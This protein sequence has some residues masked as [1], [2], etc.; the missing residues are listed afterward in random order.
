MG[1]TKVQHKNFFIVSNKIFDFDLP[2]NAIAVYC[3]LLMFADRENLSC[4]PSHRMICKK[5]NL[6]KNTVIKC[7][8]KLEVIGLVQVKSRKRWNNSNSSNM[9]YLSDLS[10]VN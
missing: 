5:C 1:D 10:V 6:S 3:C 4:F 2:A 7:L 8:R 9:Y